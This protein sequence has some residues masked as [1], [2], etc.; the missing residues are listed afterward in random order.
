MTLLNYIMTVTQN[1]KGCLC[2]NLDPSMPI[3]EIPAASIWVFLF[4]T[5]GSSEKESLVGPPLQFGLC[6]LRLWT[7]A[8]YSALS[9]INSAKA[10]SIKFTKSIGVFSW[11]FF[12]VPLVTQNGP[13]SNLQILEIKQPLSAAPQFKRHDPKGKETGEGS[14]GSNHRHWIHGYTKFNR[15][16]LIELGLGEGLT[17]PP[18]SVGHS[19][20]SCYVEGDRSHLAWILAWRS[21]LLLL[22]S[23][24]I[25]CNDGCG[26]IPGTYFPSRPRLP[27]LG[28]FLA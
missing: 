17:H 22:H 8:I 9:S 20:S 28:L 1:G 24:L 26:E 15:W 11:W 12:K 16:C 23:L 19:S 5:G 21:C 25:T 6:P 13:Q 10:C 18:P 4:K 2:L 14:G 3:T 7:V 27:N